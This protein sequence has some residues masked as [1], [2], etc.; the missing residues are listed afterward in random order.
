[1]RECIAEMGFLCL[2]FRKLESACWVFIGAE[3]NVVF[4][5]YILA[6]LDLRVTESHV[7][8]YVLFWAESVDISIGFRRKSI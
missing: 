1:M 7:T 2:E 3:V 4:L 6:N 5:T 8:C